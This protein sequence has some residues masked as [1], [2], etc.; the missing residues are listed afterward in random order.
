MFHTLRHKY[1]NYIALFILSALYVLNAKLFHRNAFEHV[2]WQHLKLELF[3]IGGRCKKRGVRCKGL[4]L[5]QFSKPIESKQGYEALIAKEPEL[6][7][8]KPV[9][10]KTGELNYLNCSALSTNNTCMQYETRP[11]LCRNY[12]YSFFIAQ[13][14]LLPGCGYQIKLKKV[15]FYM[16]CRALKHKIAQVLACQRV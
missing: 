13:D 3:M 10:H 14:R 8:F 5:A 6:A 2:L 16:T 11:Q 1:P 9:Y 4:E 12:P 7:V 15:G